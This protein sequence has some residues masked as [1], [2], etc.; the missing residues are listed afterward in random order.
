[1]RKTCSVISARPIVNT[2]R[3]FGS[4][5][6]YYPAL[7]DKGGRLVP[8]LFTATQIGEAIER[9]KDNPEDS[10]RPSWLARLVAWLG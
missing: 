4:A 1:M 8:A 2:H 6:L 5:V 10:P 3:R 7:V 9:A